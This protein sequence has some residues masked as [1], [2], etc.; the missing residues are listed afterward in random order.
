[1]IY[2]KTYPFDEACAVSPSEKEL[3]K[4]IRDHVLEYAFITETGSSF[5]D[6]DIKYNKYG[7]PFIENGLNFSISHTRGFVCCATS[8]SPVGIDAEH[9]RPVNPNIINKVCSAE[10]KRAILDSDDVAARFFKY[11]TLKESY[12]K[13][14]GMG[15]SYPMNK[16]NFSFDGNFISSNAEDAFFDTACIEGY[17]V[18][19]CTKNTV[20]KINAVK[21]P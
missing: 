12:I 5:T 14:I 13:M 4:Q 19:L 2:Y 8:L 17:I 16:I 3:A 15:L 6:F 7:K 20:C 9:I 11:W 18:A 21:L 10:E 1:M